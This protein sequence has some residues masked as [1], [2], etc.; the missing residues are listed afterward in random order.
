MWSDDLASLL[1]KPNRLIDYS[2]IDNSALINY[3]KAMQV[4]NVSPRA[5][6]NA[7]LRRARRAFEG[8]GQQPPPS[9][10]TTDEE[11]KTDDDDE[12]ME[13][14][15]EEEEEEEKQPERPRRER[16]RGEPKDFDRRRKKS[17]GRRGEVSEG[18]VNAFSVSSELR[19]NR[20]RT[21]R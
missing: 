21:R 6:N 14:P 11:R 16:K 10:P 17:M 1:F 5:N 13:N 8:A 20:A 2:E 4:A 19:R 3:Y 12:Y 15:E 9:P 7:K 18:S